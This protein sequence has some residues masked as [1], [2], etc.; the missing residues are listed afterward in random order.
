MVRLGKTAPV[1]MLAAFGACAATP[2]ITGFYSCL[3][4]RVPLLG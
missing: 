3:Y 2:A 1:L 4:V